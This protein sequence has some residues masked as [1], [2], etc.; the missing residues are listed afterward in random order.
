MRQEPT[1]VQ[2]T[3]DSCALVP[4]VRATVGGYSILMS[5]FVAG[6]VGRART[7]GLCRAQGQGAGAGRSAR[8][9]AHDGWRPASAAPLRHPAVAVS[10][11]WSFGA[12]VQ[13]SWHAWCCVLLL[14]GLAWPPLLPPCGTALPPTTWPPPCL[15]QP[16]VLQ[17][18]GVPVW[19]TATAYVCA[20]LN[21]IPGYLVRAQVLQCSWCP[22]LP[23]AERYRCSTP[24]TM[25]AH[26]PHVPRCL[27]IPCSITWTSKSC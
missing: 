21:A 11:Y 8:S 14:A 16:I 5:V 18:I 15:P 19:L 17:S 20:V 24:A 26:L 4:Q 27:P 25:P 13:A 10:G 22:G 7:V 1:A 12:A 3:A 6:R 23:E 9:H 2:A